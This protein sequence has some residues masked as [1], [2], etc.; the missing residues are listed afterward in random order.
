[1]GQSVE[2]QAGGAKPRGLGSGMLNER[3]VR[4]DRRRV[5]D[6]IASAAV[7][8][9]G[10]GI[11]ACIL[12]IFV[13]IVVQAWPLV[14]GATVSQVSAPALSTFRVDA[15]AS[16]PYKSHV[17]GI[18]NDGI[19]R[20]QRIGGREPVLAKAV[21]DSLNAAFAD[22]DGD[23]LGGIDE[24]GRVLLAPLEWKVGFAGGRRQVSPDVGET[25]RFALPGVA[26]Q[27]P[28]S[29]IRSSDQA[30][31]ALATVSAD[32]ELV[33]FRRSREVN[34]FTGEVT[35]SEDSTKLSAPEGLVALALEPELRE[36]YGADTSGKLYRWPIRSGLGE[37]AEVVDVGH[38]VSA[39]ALL[40]GGRS[41]V[42]GGHDG[43]LE[44]WFR[45]P[46]AAGGQRLQRI[47]RFPPHRSKIEHL[48][49]S[50]RDKGFVA[51]DE[52]GM[53]GIY[54]STSERVIWRGESGVESVR[55]V[56][57][58]PKADGLIVSGENGSSIV[59]VD[60][61]H[62]DVS[63]WSLFAPVW[64]E[65]YEGPELVWQ[66]SS[67]T[68]DFEP[69]YSLTPLLIGT[70]KGT[71]YS[72]L[73]A[74]PLGV[75]GAM[76][77]SHFTHPRLRNVIKPTVEIMAALPSVVLGFLAGLWLAP[78]VE[79]AF[80]SLVLM[81]ISFPFVI[82]GSGLIWERLPIKWR[83][84]M[85]VGAE[86]FA[87]AIALAAAGFAC[88]ALSDVFE[89][90]AFGGDFQAW[91]LRTSGLH[92]DQRNAIVVGLAMGFA[93][94]PIVFAISEDA[95]SNVPSSL[96]S[97]SLGLGATR[98]QTV[99]R[100]VLPTASPGIFSAIMVGFGRAVG[101]TMIVLMATGNTPIR[102]WNP[103]NGFRTLSANIAVEIPEAPHLGTL[104]RVLFLAA[105][106][107]FLFTFFI[108]TAAELVRQRLR[109]RYARL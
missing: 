17:A 33:L 91:L 42:L 37:A 35:T 79:D 99:T 75:L 14:R 38:K 63:L 61:P 65:G 34:D 51:V 101:E 50:R 94:I 92:Y 32:G 62:P 73:I 77:V 76:Y 69:K 74:I 7:S 10:I 86:V 108:N 40:L 104:Y 102:D 1:M 30:T 25:L 82:V 47:R 98:W 106:L 5:A 68:D 67:G 48:A 84:R 89:V 81:V 29:A 22:S 41:L 93:V 43:S 31:L 70:L 56:A 13:F 90:A 87:F 4:M 44:V 107:L 28:L 78:R 54:H 100:V 19:L 39:L 2:T 109:E 95:F 71:F 72:L 52:D 8:A 103:F 60:N 26:L 46:L 96:V 57:F 53:V 16:D 18:G 23:F 83:S 27:A 88:V 49:S 6:V 36:L 12:A 59:D 9:G 58:T 15:L 105:L 45:A 66:S 24:R 3:D 55:A 21:A 85:P 80:S 11:I 97:A 20:V 64:Y